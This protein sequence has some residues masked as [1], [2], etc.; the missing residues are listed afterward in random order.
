MINLFEGVPLRHLGPREYLVARRPTLIS[1][2]LGSCLALTLFD[3]VTRVGGMCHAFLP[4]AA[5]YPGDEEK[6]KF[7]D[8]AMAY[9][10]DTFATHCGGLE[11]VEAKLFGGGEIMDRLRGSSGE[12]R[13]SVGC[14]NV[15]QAH[16]VLAARGIQPLAEDT[17]GRQGRKVLFLTHTGGVWVKKLHQHNAALARE[18]RR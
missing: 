3:P 5:E 6:G 10:L 11:R 7:V 4:T 15:E 18:L 8:T 17:G 1:T 16:Q 13:S 14:R 12:C 2:V 9:M